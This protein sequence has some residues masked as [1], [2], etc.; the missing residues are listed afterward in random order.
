MSGH[1][2]IVV[3]ASAG[4]VETLCQLVSSLPQD[5][6]AAVFI[7][8][9]IPVH[10]KS[11]LPTI[12]N[13]AIAKQHG[14]LSS[15]QARHPTDGEVISPGRIYVAPS[16]KH[17]LIKDRCIH[18]ARSAR[19]NSHR[20]AIDPLF[21]TAARS[22]GQRV[23]GVILSGLL[24]DGTAGLAV[25][26]QRGGV[27]IAQDPEEA[28]YSGMPTSAIENVDVDYI[29]KVGDIAK[30]LTYLAD[31]PVVESKAPIPQLL[32]M[33]ANIA[34]F[35]LDTMQ[36]PNR[37]GKPSGFACPECSGTL[38]ELQEGKLVRFRCRTGHAYSINSLLAEQNDALEVALWS[39][40]RALEEKAALTDRMAKRAQT[41][42]QTISAQRFQTQ[43]H[44]SQQSAVLVRQMLLSSDTSEELAVVNDQLE[45]QNLVSSVSPSEYA[46][47]TNKHVIAIALTA[48]TK[49]LKEVLAQIEGIES[50]IIVTQQGDQD[51]ELVA[52][53]SSGTSFN[54][55]LAASGDILRPG[56]VYIAPKSHHILVNPDGSLAL[57]PS[58]LV[59]FAKPS[60]D[61]LFESVAGSFREKVIALILNPTGKDG[62]MGLRA[63]RETGGYAIVVQGEETIHQEYVDNAQVLPLAEVAQTLVKLTKIK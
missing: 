28:L 50:A 53:L 25:I 4:G 6:A 20:P 44:D 19:E 14:E 52:N 51:Q 38:W 10:G 57:L 21:R 5:L 41:N 17:L 49:D 48:D 15:L 22:Y 26:K 47:D 30:T 16:D 34:H 63:I 61:L 46:N 7:V 36:N 23:V 45:Q 60:A 29:L 2:I 27:A 35:D 62:I 32:E 58:K 55:K 12:L 40:L 8:L 54:V 42:S 37:P 43:A 31:Q 56:T 39:A 3:G 13:R 11:M 59:H 18:L 9:H 1:D 24:D 33:E